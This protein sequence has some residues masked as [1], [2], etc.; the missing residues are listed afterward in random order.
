MI[1]DQRWYKKPDG[2]PERISAGG[3]I[4]RLRQGKYSLALVCEG[5]LSGYFLPKGGV[6]AGEDLE[7]A[8][9]RE[10]QEEAGLKYLELVVYLG[11]RQRLNFRRSRWVTTH[12]FL[13]KTDGRVGKPTDGEH[14]YHC[15]WFMLDDLPEM[16]W[17]EQR[18]LVEEVRARLAELLS[19]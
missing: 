2:I 15:E 12:Y 5:D 13:F 14:A 1:I 10:I 11:E 19:A 3:I 8:A 7:T 16:L 6:E 17:P 18:T 9:R 4:L